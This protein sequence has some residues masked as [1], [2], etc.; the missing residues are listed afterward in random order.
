MHNTVS[1]YI[2]GLHEFKVV[3]YK[4]VKVLLHR[5]NLGYLESHSNLKFHRVSRNSTTD[6]QKS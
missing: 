3:W 2:S 1:V 5:Q 4:N 6:V